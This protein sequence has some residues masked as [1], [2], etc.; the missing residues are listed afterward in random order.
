MRSADLAPLDFYVR[1]PENELVYATEESKGIVTE[2]INAAF[3]T[4]KD[5][6]RLGTTTVGVPKRCRICILRRGRQL[7]QNL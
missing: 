5:E 6:M 2:R 3:D 1:V 4:M 7:E